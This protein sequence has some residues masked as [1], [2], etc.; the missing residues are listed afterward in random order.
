VSGGES[1]TSLLRRF[2]KFAAVGGSGVVVNLGLY[3][4]LTRGLG[5]LCTLSGRNVSYAVSVEISIITNFLL[6]DLWT[7]S[8]RRRG[9]SWPTRFLRFHLVSFV[10]FGINWGVFAV[11]NWLLVEKGMALFGNVSLLGWSG[12]VDDLVAACLGIIAAMMWNFFANLAW[13]WRSGR[14]TSGPKG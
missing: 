8:D 13:T 5:L 3:A 14:A 9:L 12:N 10:G 6:N 11:L 2:L 7:F 4:A 1:E